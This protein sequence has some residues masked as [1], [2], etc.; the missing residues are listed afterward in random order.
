MDLIFAP[1]LSTAEKVTDI[2]GRGVGMDA[3]KA[4]V[5]KMNGKI[6]V[7]SEKGRGTTFV[8]EF[9]LTLSVLQSLLV[10]AG[11]HVYALPIASVFELVKVETSQIKSLLSRGALDVRGETLGFESLSRVLGHFGLAEGPG[12]VELGGKRSVLVLQAGPNK[13]A[14]GVD[15]ILR[16]EEIAVKPLTAEL[17]E[18][19]ALAGAS[20]LGDGRAILIL[21]P[22]K[23]WELCIGGESRFAA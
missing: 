2:S 21:D 3:V 17:S 10:E 9:P 7:Q 22:V 8:L 5:T 15:R 23:I 6:T 16:K 13:I 12:A 20:V 1:G 4:G 11:G 18:L 14:L 19:P